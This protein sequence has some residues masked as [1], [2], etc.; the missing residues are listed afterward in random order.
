[1]SEVSDALPRVR[2]AGS[3]IVAAD[4][5]VCARARALWIE[6]RPAPR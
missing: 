3:A 5:T 2:E 1:M 6:L 4:G